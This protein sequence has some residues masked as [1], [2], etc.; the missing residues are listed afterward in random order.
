MRRLVS[1]DWHLFSTTDDFLFGTMASEMFPASN[2]KHWR[3]TAVILG[4]DNLADVPTTLHQLV[5]PSFVY[6]AVQVTDPTSWVGS[7]SLADRVQ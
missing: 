2:S 4:T 1:H 5:V 7:A 3:L 6:G